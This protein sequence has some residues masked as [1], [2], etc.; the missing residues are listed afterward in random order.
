[1]KND[2]GIINFILKYTIINDFE[3]ESKDGKKISAKPEISSASFKYKSDLTALS[4]IEIEKLRET[5]RE[6]N[7]GSRGVLSGITRGRESSD[8]SKPET[9]KVSTSREPK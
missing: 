5:K 7:A 4:W 1:M 9:T 3:K 2:S 6:R 8:V